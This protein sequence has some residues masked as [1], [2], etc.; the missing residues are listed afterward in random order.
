MDRQSIVQASSALQRSE[1]CTLSPLA[2]GWGA[3]HA[4]LASSLSEVQSAPC[5]NGCSVAPW[6]LSGQ[7]GWDGME[8]RRTASTLQGPRVNYRTAA[9]A[10]APGNCLASLLVLPAP[11]APVRQGLQHLD[12]LSFSAPDT[13]TPTN[14]QQFKFAKP[15][16]TDCSIPPNC[17]H[18]SEA[19]ERL[20]TQCHIME[21][22]RSLG[23]SSVVVCD[24]CGYDADRHLSILEPLSDAAFYLSH[25]L[26]QAANHGFPEELL[27]CCGGGQVRQAGRVRQARA[28]RAPRD[29]R[30]PGSA[31][32]RSQH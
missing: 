31:E 15:K 26:I 29:P 23:S 18:D 14:A 17:M 32:G 3:S 7:L 24:V 11:R 9:A 21:A 12:C 10:P 22:S 13:C 20:W 1:L 28:A 5:P 27:P 6:S 8:W 16:P 2:G 19:Y 4:T 30:R 25:C